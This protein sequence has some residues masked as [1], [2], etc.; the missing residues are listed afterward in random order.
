M[1]RNPHPEVTERR[2]LAAAKKLFAEK[3]YDKTSIQ[4]IIDKLGDLSRGAIYHHFKSK[5]AILERLNTDDWHASQALCDEIAKRDDMNAMEKLRSL[6]A[7]SLGDAAHLALVKATVPF[8]DDPATFT[9]NMRFWSTELPKNFEPLIEEGQLDGSIPTEYPRE[10]AQLLA[11][12]CNYWLMP[13]FFPA[14]RTQLRYRLQ[15]LATML[16]ALHAPVFDQHLIDLA[17]DGLRRRRQR[18]RRRATRRR[19]HQSGKRRTLDDADSGAGRGTNVSPR[20]STDLHTVSR[21]E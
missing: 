7:N 6:F 11:L 1:A 9:A 13:C 20:S 18:Q 14:T 5:E 4:D 10:V 2:I 12:L 16:D 15:C 19:R 21:Y 8:F 3:G 17:T